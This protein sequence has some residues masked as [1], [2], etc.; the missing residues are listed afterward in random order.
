MHHYI[1]EA[2]SD[3]SFRSKQHRFPQST[4]K[5]WRSYVMAVMAVAVT[6]FGT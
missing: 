6:V 4:I 3:D 2:V 1:Q 5:G